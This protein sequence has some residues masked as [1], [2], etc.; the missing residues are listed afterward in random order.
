MLLRGKDLPKRAKLSDYLSDGHEQ[1]RIAGLSDGQEFEIDIALDGRY[2]LPDGP[3]KWVNK[4]KT[5]EGVHTAM[6]TIAESSNF[7]L[8]FTHGAEVQNSRG[9]GITINDCHDFNAHD[10]FVRGARTAGISVHESTGF[11][12]HHPTTIDT[13]NYQTKRVDV[14]KW[15]VSGSIKFVGC[16]GYKLIRPISIDH[17]GNAI[18]TTE[19]SNG[20]WE[21]PITIDTHGASQYIN[22][23]P[24][25]TIRD[26]IHIGDSNA[27]VINSEEEN[28]GDSSGVRM[29]NCF[30]LDAKWGLGFW[31]NEGK[32]GIVLKDAHALNCIFISNEGIKLHKRANIESLD[33]TGTLHFTPKQVDA[34]LLKRLRQHG[35]LLK[36]AVMEHASLNAHIVDNILKLLRSGFVKLR[37]EEEKPIEE[38]PHF[39]EGQQ[40]WLVVTVDD[41][42]K[43]YRRLHQSLFDKYPVGG[44]QVQEIATKP[45]AGDDKEIQRLQN[46]IE[47]AMA[48]LQR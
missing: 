26:G 5:R 34:E 17:M 7:T 14:N 46:K 41:P 40:L 2:T 35:K 38:E 24:G 15:N 16:D 8:L 22:A 1:V 36:A 44:V 19:S 28:T 27:W 18:T 3:A 4:D 45:L 6:L 21:S 13:S 42:N 10:L 48:V 33:T 31:G 30:A 29:E 12:L 9:R 43:A 47:D 37:G 20:T 11:T 39:T 32:E 23:S 25:H